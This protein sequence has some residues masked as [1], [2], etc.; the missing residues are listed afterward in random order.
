MAISLSVIIPAYNSAQHIKLCL[1]ALCAFGD[2]QLQIVVVD[3]S[4]TDGTKE[5]AAAFPVTILSTQDSHGPAF[6]RNMGARAATAD[7]LV[8]LDSDVCIRS[9]T[10]QRIRASFEASP[11]LDALIGSYDSSPHCRDFLSQYRNLMH[12]FVHQ[13]G[14]REASTFW[15]GCGAIRRSVFL[16]HRGL[17]K[18]SDALRSR[19]S[20]WATA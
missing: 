17:T 6:A 14:A 15:S 1:E 5:A 13:T 4:S 10:L 16:E 12:A 18:R 2:S 20:S 19:I 3:D 8:F 11:D 9:D 7:V